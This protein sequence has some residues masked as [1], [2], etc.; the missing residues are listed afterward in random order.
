M[1]VQRANESVDV[2]LSQFGFQVPKTALPDCG[3][4]DPSVVVIIITASTSHKAVG[5]EKLYLIGK[6]DGRS[7]GYFSEIKIHR[8]KEGGLSN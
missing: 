3:H 2:L 4:E 8:E 1:G 5:I 6:S 7:I